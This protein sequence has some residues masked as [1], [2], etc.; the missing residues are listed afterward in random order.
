MNRRLFGALAVFVVCGSTALGQSADS[1]LRAANALYS[2]G[3]YE[4][5]ELAARR[6]MEQGPMADSIR[7]QA[8][9]IIAFALVAQG[10]NDLA[11][12]HFEAILQISP[13]FDLD[14]VLTSPK[15]LTV[16][17]QAKLRSG[18][19]RQTAP[20]SG[21]ISES[22]T[23]GVT[24]RAIVFPGWEQYYRGRATAGLV[25]AGAGVLSL[26]SA[27]ACEILRARAR[28]DYLS[29]TQPAD[30]ASKYDTYNRYYRGEVYSFIAFTAVYVASELD[31]F[32]NDSQSVEIRPSL[33]PVSGSGVVLTF[34]W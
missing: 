17:Q 11:R 6:L 26:G 7:I 27:V 14:P 32:L 20:G 34:R 3:A 25:F 8:E 21:A 22:S 18:V 13:S 19:A 33:R 15:I 2:N 5:A 1:T 16:F 30:I 10:K 4:S 31:V 29:A 9:Q 12:E 24:F 23:A 28:R